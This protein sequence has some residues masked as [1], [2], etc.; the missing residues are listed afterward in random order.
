M[1]K[2]VSDKNLITQTVLEQITLDFTPDDL[3]QA[4]LTWWANKRLTGGLRLTES[5]HVAFLEAGLEFYDIAYDNQNIQVL[6]SINLL[7]LDR[8]LPCPY[9]LVVQ[10]RTKFIRIFDSRIAALIHLHG[11]LRAYI[12][13]LGK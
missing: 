1:S 4:L 7:K 9:H 3:N 8:Y 11:G 13:G 10:N 5:G 12:N 6:T 2:F